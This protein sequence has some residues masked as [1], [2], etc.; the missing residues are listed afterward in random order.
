MKTQRIFYLIILLTFPL[1]FYQQSL[2]QATNAVGNTQVLPT[3]F[4]GWDNVGLANQPL[5]ILTQ[6]AEDINLATFAGP[7]PVWNNVRQKIMGNWNNQY[8]LIA[9]GD[10]GTST[11]PTFLPQSL[12]HSYVQG[13]TIA[14]HQ[15]SNDDT[16]GGSAPAGYNEG[17][18]IGIQYSNPGP[19]YDSN[20]PT[21]PYT[22]AALRQYQEA[23]MDFYLNDIAHTIIQPLRMRITYG[24]GSSHLD[25][26]SYLNPTTDQATGVTRVI[27]SHA[28]EVP[29]SDPR[30]FYPFTEAVAMLNLGENHTTLPSSGDPYL[31]GGARRWMDVGT[32]YRF[33]TDNMYTGLKDNGRNNK[34]AVINWGDDPTAPTPQPNHLLFNFTSVGGIT[35]SDDMEGLEVAR[36]TVLNGNF[37]SVGIGGDPNITVPYTNL[38]STGVE[39]GNTLEINSS[40]QNATSSTGGNS[41][42]R[43]TDLNTSSIPAV[44]PG[45]GILSVT[46]AGDVIYVEDIGNY[47]GATP[48]RPIRADYEIP[49]SGVSTSFDYY[50]TGQKN[51]STDVLI[52]N[53]CSNSTPYAKLQA[54]QPTTQSSSPVGESNAARFTNS[55]LNLH[56]IGGV[57]I[58]ETSH[59]NNYGLKGFA[60]LETG[61]SNYGVFGTTVN[62][63]MIMGNVN[64]GVY[65][66][67]PSTKVSTAKKRHA[68]VGDLGVSTC[69]TF[70]CP[71]GPHYAGYFNGDVISTTNFFQTS[72]LNLKD[73]ILDVTDPMSI[74]SQLNPKTFTYKQADN[75]SMQLPDGTHFG[76]IAQDVESILPELVKSSV[77]PAR[78]DSM[79]VQ[80]YAEINFKAINYIELIPLLIGAI[81]QQQQDMEAMQDEI[82]LLNGG[83][84]RQ[85]HG[86]G[87]ENSDEEQGNKSSIDVE[88]Q[89]VNAIVLNQNV[90]NPFAEQTTISYFITDD[91]GKA[92]I[93]FYDS[94]GTILKIV[95]I[96]EKGAGQL[97]VF[98]DDLSSGSYR[99]TLIA[100]GNVIETKTMVKQ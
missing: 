4:L 44:N 32:F 91:V 11:A 8:G 12:L 100:D 88:L 9:I 23:P 43:F 31:L 30:A 34:D 84:N 14:Y 61:N 95:D 81:K 71:T 33:D 52:G 60:G 56:A 86:A 20:G 48:Q 39:P 92:Q 26:P 59:D 18:A 65:G 99:Y 2:G 6:R 55:T 35:Q 29:A 77:H 74:V 94:K 38:Y 53:P 89:N 24:V 19:F 68:V 80:T 37:G 63:P 13:N 36:M 98:A 79:G 76:L 3:D 7:G 85:G 1:A 42:L 49:L 22:I 73:N 5:N 21:P 75:I 27:I 28:G 50:F 69:T 41:G 83:G 17:F 96:K 45:K 57:G 58:S 66:Y 10:C 16:G 87:E 40:D 25:P 78:F 67:S 62:F 54:Y 93:F 97:N 64:V 46:S 72:D 47:C 15:F 70:P 51:G 82:T 90:P